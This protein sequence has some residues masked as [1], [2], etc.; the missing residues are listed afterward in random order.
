MSVADALPVY[1]HREHHSIHVEA[2]PAD[3][4]AAAKS[5][6]LADVPLLRT[7]FRLRGLGTPPRG[8]LW[9]AMGR[10]G[11]RAGGE[12][13]LT[14]IG[15]P[16][17]ITGGR[18]PD[19]QDFAAFD[20]PRYAKMAVDMIAVPEGGGARLATETRVFLTD[21]YAQR[22]FRAYWLVIRPFS[23]LTRRSWLKAAKRRAET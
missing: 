16:W 14:L 21:P 19:V 8:S 17:R 7:L 20:E 13:T 23:G 18:R 10:N 2:S 15:R 11:F 12:E 3:A 22:R 5:I 1:H 9:E 6:T 4:V